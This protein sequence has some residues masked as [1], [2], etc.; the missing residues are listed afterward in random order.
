[1]EM[2]TQDLVILANLM[3]RGYVTQEQLQQAV[4][5]YMS[6]FIK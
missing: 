1:M 6:Q 2:T 4:E 3:D 5:I